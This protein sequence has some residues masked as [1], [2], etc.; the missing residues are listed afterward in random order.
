MRFVLVP[1]VLLIVQSTAMADQVTVSGD[2]IYVTRDDCAMLQQHHPS[3][4]V[5]Y[6]PGVDVHGKYVAPADLPGTD[7]S[8]ILPDTIHF[9]VMA[10]PLTYGGA[11]SNQA[12]TQVPGRYANTAMP[13]AHVDVDL[14]T[15]DVMLN[16]QP[17]SGVQTKALEEACRKAGYR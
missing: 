15:G 12:L 2:T 5:T 6:R 16:G 3:A 17:L 11:A 13:V 8:N 7:Y 1:V 9:D 14:R 10:N 4:D